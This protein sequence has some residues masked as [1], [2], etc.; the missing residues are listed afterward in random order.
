MTDALDTRN[1][2]TLGETGENVGQDESTNTQKTSSPD[3]KS[4][5]KYYQSEKDKLFEE[6]KRLAKFEQLGEFLE[7]R[8]DIIESIKNQVDGVPEQSPLEPDEFDPWEAFNA[9]SSK[10]YQYREQQTQ[11]QIISQVQNQVEDELRDIKRENSK[12]KLSQ[13]LTDMGMPPEDQSSFFEFASKNPT[14]YGLENV[15][16]MWQAVQGVESGQPPV[17]Q[18]NLNDQVRAMQ[19]TPAQVGLASG[20]RSVSKNEEDAVWES[21]VGAQN[22]S[23]VL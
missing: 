21:I 17:T 15:V 22:R 4:Q 7:S 1:Q 11:H 14:E 3:W 2:D 5:A 12:I 18:P 6:N 20:E 10:S 19:R 16:K 8:P 9:P 23:N 13:K